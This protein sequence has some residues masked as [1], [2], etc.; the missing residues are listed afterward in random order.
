[1]PARKAFPGRAARQPRVLG[2]ALLS[3]TAL[4]FCAPQIAL[5]AAAPG[6]VGD[7]GPII[8]GDKSTKCIEDANNDTANDTPIVID[9]CNGSADQ[10]WTVEADGTLQ[11]NGKCMDVYRDG[12][13]NKTKVEL[14]ECHGSPNQQWVQSGTMLVNPA[15]GKCLDDPRFDTTNGTQL[16]IYTCNGGANQSWNLP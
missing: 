13:A 12:K 6:T 15:S 2:I 7:T 14:W 5:A 16:E 11:V 10:T 8:S 4:L 3:L 1:M 9:D